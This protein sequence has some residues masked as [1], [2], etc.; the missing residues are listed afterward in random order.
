MSSDEMRFLLV[1]DPTN[2]GVHRTVFAT[3]RHLLRR[4]LELRRPVSYVDATNLTKRDRRPYIRLAQF[5]D[6]KVEAVFFDTPLEVCKERNRS[7][8]RKVPDEAIDAMAA[9]LSPPVPEEGFDTVTVY[10]PTAA[11]QPT[12]PGQA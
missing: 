8:E 6:A 2:Q 7:R 11:V 1:D 3:V 4:R 9:R 10:R 12:M 5:F